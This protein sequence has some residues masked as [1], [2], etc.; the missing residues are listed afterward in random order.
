ME[1]IQSQESKDSVSNGMGIVP[2]S[3]NEFIEQQLDERISLIESEFNADAISVSGLMYPGLD[4]IIRSAVEK[5]KQEDPQREKLV[6]I[7]TTRGGIIEVVHRVVDT[8]R[9][10]YK[11]VYFV[12][13]N[14]AYS[15]GTVF[16]MS[17]D[18]IFMDYYS[19]LGPIDPQIELKSG[20]WVSAL[21][22]LQKY[23]ALIRKARRG[24][25]TTAEVQ[26]L[27]E[28]DQAE[29]YSFEQ[30]REL[31][32]TLLKEWLVKYKFKDWK[33]TRTR[34][35]TVTSSMKT[36]AAAFIAKELN[37]TEKWHTHGYGISMD[38]LNKDLKLIIDDFGSDPQMSTYIRCYHDLL[39]DYM[40]KTHRE[41]V[42]HFSGHFRPVYYGRPHDA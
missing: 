24:S 41:G 28:F 14:Y 15:A 22:Y 11:E 12:V 31:S 42:V 38:V 9:R 10:H 26:I 19:R 34:G 36:G 30:A 6:I 20:R 23:N 8:L 18:K 4:D 27:I 1:D 2:T 39:T 7:L 29:L 16:A 32:I 13:P 5:K 25:I 40:V 33:K 17:G 21:G 37:K 3:A 35:K